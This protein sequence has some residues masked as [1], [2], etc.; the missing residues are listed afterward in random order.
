M[1]IES[2]A[3]KKLLLLIILLIYN[4]NYHTL[5]QSNVKFERYTIEN[6]L[7]SNQIFQVYQDSKGFIWIATRDG[8]N[9]YDGYYFQ[10]FKN[11]PQDSTSI[12]HNAIQALCED[13]EGILWIGTGNGLSYYNSTQ[14]NFK[15]IILD[16][17]NKDKYINVSFIYEDKAKNLWIAT[18][19]AGLACYNKKNNQFSFFVPIPNDKNSISSNYIKAI[20]EDKNGTLW[21]ATDNGICTL[22]EK[23][24]KT[25]F[26]TTYSSI[27]NNPNSIP[28]KYVKGIAIDEEETIWIGSDGGVSK[29]THTNKEIG[30]FQ[31]FTNNPTNPNSLG[32]NY[33]K[34]VYMD[35][36]GNLWICADAGVARLKK[37]NKNIGFF[38]NFRHNSADLSSISSSYSK[39][40]FEDRSGQIWVATDGGV[41][42]FDPQRERFELY[43]HN[44]IQISLPN[45]T[46]R[47]ITQA[48][49]Q[50][51]W[52]GSENG[53]I[54][55]KDNIFS[56]FTYNPN[57]KNSLVNNYINYVLETKNGEFWIGTDGGISVLQKDQKT[58]T[59]FTHDPNNNT[60]IIRNTI[61]C[62][63][64]DNNENL[65]FATWEGIAKLNRE[66]RKKGI[67]TNFP[68]ESYSSTGNG[69]VQH[70]IQDKE[71]IIW[72]ATKHGLVRYIEKNNTFIA[73]THSNKDSLSISSNEAN[74][75]QE[76]NGKGLWIGTLGGGLNY[77]DKA[78]QK[79]VH[80][81]EDDGL[82]S[83][84][85]TGILVD[86]EN[87]LWLSS[88]K[89][90]TKFTPPKNI[91]DSKDKGI[92]KN[93]TEKDGLQG[94]EF[95][96]HAFCKTANGKFYFGGNHG[97]SA[98][99]PKNIKNENQVLPVYITD[100]KLFNKSVKVGIGSSYLLQKSIT[101]TKEL[102]LSYLDNFFSFDF[103]A[104]NYRNTEKNI[105]AYKM[106]GFDKD[107]IY[108]TADKRF[109]TYTNLSPKEYVFRVKAANSLGVWNEDGISLK[110][111]IKPPIW[112]TTWFRLLVVALILGAVVALYRYRVSQIEKQKKELE[113]QVQIRT[114]EVVRQK[115]EISGQNQRLEEQKQEILTQNEELT[116][117]Q[118]EIMS[119]RDNI[120]AKNVVLLQQKLELEK[121]YQ[122]I[123][124]LSEI[125]Q[126]ITSSLNLD[127]LIATVYENVN[128]LMY[129]SGFGIGIFDE[130]KQV[131]SF[132]GFIE[133][134]E[135]LPYH[136]YKITEKENLTIFCIATQTEILIND[137]AKEIY[138]YLPDFSKDLTVD[139]GDIPESLIYLPLLLDNKVTGVITVQSFQKNAYQTNHVAILRTLASYIAIALD[140]AKAYEEIA[141][142]QEKLAAQNTKV[143]DSIRYG[144]T[145]Q[146]AMLPQQKEFQEHWQDSFIIYKPKDVVSGDFY[147]FSKVI[148]SKFLAIVDCTGHGVPGA[149]M[150]MIGMSLL[151][152]AINQ[153]QIHAPM[154]VLEYLHHEIRSAL[155]QDETTNR[156]GM[157]IC[158]CKV[159]ALNQQFRITFGSAKRPLFYTENGELK[160]LRGSRK[161]I[162]GRSKEE[163]HF[164]EIEIILTKGEMLYLSTD[165]F[166]DQSNMQRDKFSV[167]NLKNMFQQYAKENCQTQQKL[168]TQAL[169]EHQQSAEQ[170]D[171]ITLIGVR[172]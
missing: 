71:G 6:G 56:T 157:D 19:G 83:N 23:D 148:D 97:I 96:L 172:L 122:S 34:S 146:K 108:V 93:F 27:P 166:A 13:S 137:L 30:K 82:I 77:F 94:N 31:T 161:N 17:K 115:E 170:R 160:E 22:Q 57:Q 25:G 129:A 78:S 51:I 68:Q 107:W 104:L 95:H 111:K 43:Q 128:S 81:T 9:R 112:E 3:M 60:S 139:Y 171:D 11:I 44:P 89:G 149:F 24:K 132:S 72:L 40:V 135:V 8:L 158:L 144:E 145:I 99:F 21:I 59:N 63:F 67:F 12:A 120:E 117:Q 75:L 54:R 4:L 163:S 85:I 100:F 119:Q 74:I 138:N 133:R 167:V 65:W 169:Q 20:T 26:F 52:I 76:I 87:N 165:G 141:K 14:Q 118:E 125:G 49:D 162:G 105:Y 102:N 47:S 98:F 147:W 41:N 36:K 113:K 151:H 121:S 92:I 150:S 153:Q 50:T 155:K 114:A 7:S 1:S 86:E 101:E 80:F 69:Q 90:L 127:N 5:A 88:H 46:I 134:N 79:F 28:S 73:Y 154:K 91:F 70:I 109:A 156:D 84:F 140:N 61:N 131:V 143:M 29:L 62:I 126:K 37:E 10:N 142:T 124:T 39:N 15:N 53:L 136:E 116:Q 152:E 32:S 2:I 164:E 33:V 110:I 55:W 159:T 35:K 130:K 106:E 58:F 103:T 168:F 18:N 123:S 16:N 42:K 45:N 66:N 64:E 38:D 48:K